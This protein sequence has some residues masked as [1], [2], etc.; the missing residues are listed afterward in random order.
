[1]AEENTTNTDENSKLV[2]LLAQFDDP[3]SLVQ[4]C[5][6]AREAGYTKTDAYS[7]FP[8]HGIDPALG[9]KRTI[10]PFIVLGIALGAVCIGLGMQWYTNTDSGSWS[11]AFPGYPFKISGKPYFS[12]PAN[13]PVTFEVIVLSSAFAAFLGMWFLNKL[14]MFSNPLHR[15]SRFKRATNDKFFLMI[16]A[17]DE[18]FDRSSTEGELNQW[19]AVAIEECRQDLTDNVLP[20]WLRLVALLGALLMLLPPVIIFRSMGMVNRAPRLHFMPDMDWQEKF[21]TQTLGPELVGE[22]PLFLDQRSMRAPVA[23][24]VSWGNLEA[25]S[26]MYRGIKQDYKPAVAVTMPTGSVRTSLGGQDQEAAAP[27]EED[28][29]QYVTEFP[30]DIKVDADLLARGQ[31]RFN[32]YCSVCHGYSGNGDGLVNQRAL[33]LAATSKATWTTAKSLHDPIVKDPAK[34]PVGRIFDTITNGRN[35]MGP[36]KAQIPAEDRWAIVAYVKA[37]QETGIQPPGAVVAPEGEKTGDDAK[38]TP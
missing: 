28:L 26:E 31:N 29:N 23:G 10:L 30:A 25:D 22:K 13:I 14:P 35:T 6:Q 33:A 11:P 18:N 4:A 2:G 1:M 37:L 12:L 17:S 21:K 3:D 5:N 34:N 27:I 24:S 15:I 36:Y 9:I 7:P 38:P 8:V 32:I 19:G 16:E 20:S